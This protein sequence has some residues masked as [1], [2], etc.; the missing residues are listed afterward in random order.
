M[1]SIEFDD[2][3]DF[4]AENTSIYSNASNITLGEPFRV[5]TTE[6]VMSQ[7]N[8]EMKNVSEVLD[9]S[10]FWWFTL[11]L[12][13]IRLKTKHFV[14]DTANDNTNHNEPLQMGDAKHY[15]PFS[16]FRK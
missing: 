10:S 7:M 6:D 11:R 3:S 15:G 16:S 1:S 2:E 12:P 14:P 5:I 4:D 8:E 13:R 9:V